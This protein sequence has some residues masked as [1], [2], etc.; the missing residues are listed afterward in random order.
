[1]SEFPEV[2]ISQFCFIFKCQNIFN[3]LPNPAKYLFSKSPLIEHTQYII[4]MK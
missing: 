1:M 4:E 3:L 2:L